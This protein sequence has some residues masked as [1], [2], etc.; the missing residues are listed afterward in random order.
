MSQVNSNKLLTPRHPD[1][2]VYVTENYWAMMKPNYLKKFRKIDDDDTKFSRC[3]MHLE[4]E[5]VEDGMEQR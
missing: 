3:A 2:T 5:I 1:N 4:K